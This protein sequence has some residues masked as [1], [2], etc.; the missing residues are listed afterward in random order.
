MIEKKI[1]LTRPTALVTGASSGIGLEIARLLAAGGYNLILV[2]RSA[3]R[4]ESL[5]RELRDRHCVSVLSRPI[6]L[7]EPDTARSL[8]RELTEAVV[9]VDV[10]VNNA[11]GGLHGLFSEQDDKFD[12]PTC[13][14]EHRSADDAHATSAARDVGPAKPPDPQCCFACRVSAGKR[15][16]LCITRASPLSCRF[17]RVWLGSC[18]ER[19]L[20]SQPSVP[21]RPGHPSSRPPGQP[22]P[23]STNGCW[24]CLRPPLRA[25]AIAA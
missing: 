23:H 24:P 17:P 11:G 13:D 12:R 20:P 3:D 14:A 2:A 1:A 7:Y 18:A 22:K 16:R 15:E 25:G 21:G 5:A 19:A 4:L 6:D 10:L 8:W 9:A